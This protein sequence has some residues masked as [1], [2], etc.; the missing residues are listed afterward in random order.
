[1][2]DPKNKINTK[3][4]FT[5]IIDIGKKLGSPLDPLELASVLEKEKIKRGQGTN[6]VLNDES[7]SKYNDEEQM[8]I[9]EL[10]KNTQITHN[11]YKQVEAFPMYKPKFGKNNVMQLL[12]PNINYSKGAEYNKPDLEF[13]WNGSMIP[14][15]NMTKDELADT[16]PFLLDTKNNKI[17]SMDKN[18]L[19]E[20]TDDWSFSN[21]GQNIVKTFSDPIKAFGAAVGFDRDV[22][23]DFLQNLGFS[24][25]A[26]LALTNYGDIAK[27]DT[28]EGKLAKQMIE[29]GTVNAK[30]D[31]KKKD[32]DGNDR[33]MWKTLTDDHDS[34]Q[35]QIRSVWGP[36]TMYNNNLGMEL[37]ETSNDFLLDSLGAANFIF[38]YAPKKLVGVASKYLMDGQYDKQVEKEYNNYNAWAEGRKSAGSEEEDLGWNHNI[39]NFSKGV[40]NGVAQVASS[41]AMGGVGKAAVWGLSKAGTQMVA[42]GIMTG[43]TKGAIS[44]TGNALFKL[45]PRI[46]KAL[47]T[48]PATGFGYT[49]AASSANKEA[50]QSGINAEASLVMAGIAALAVVGSEKLTGGNWV[51]KLLGKEVAEKYGVEVAKR[52]SNEIKRANRLQFNNEITETVLN[53]TASKG[54]IKK[55]L[56]EAYEFISKDATNP[57]EG[58]IQGV[59]KEGGQEVI[60]DTINKSAQAGFNAIGDASKS[61]GLDW[62]GD[63]ERYH[64]E[65]DNL[66]ED[67]AGSFVMGGIV[68]GMTGAVSY[69][70]EAE[71]N[72]ERSRT[73]EIVAARLK[74]DKVSEKL[75]STLD[76]MKDKGLFGSSSLSSENEKVDKKWSAKIFDKFKARKDNNGNNVELDDNE[77][78][79]KIHRQEVEETF[80]QVDMVVAELEKVYGK[81]LDKTTEE[82]AELVSSI[83]GMSENT[84]PNTDI[85]RGLD[86]IPE[87]NTQTATIRDSEGNL[88]AMSQEDYDEL[89]KDK[90]LE[91]INNN[92]QTLT[93]V[94]RAKEEVKLLRQTL[95]QS[96]SSEAVYVKKQ[97]DTAEANIAHLLY[98][99]NTSNT[100]GLGGID[101]NNLIV[102]NGNLKGIKK[103]INTDDNNDTQDVYADIMVKNQYMKANEALTKLKEDT[104]I[105][106]MFDNM[107]K[108]NKDLR[109]LDFN[110]ERA[111]PEEKAAIEVAIKSKENELETIEN[112]IDTA[113]KDKKYVTPA[114]AKDLRTLMQ[115]RRVY[116]KH[117]ES[118]ITKRFEFF[119]EKAAINVAATY[120]LAAL[121]TRAKESGMNRSILSPY[122]KAE[123]EKR[124]KYFIDKIKNQ[125]VAS[126]KFN[127]DQKAAS[128]R[129]KKMIEDN[130]NQFN[131]TIIEEMLKYYDKPSIPIAQDLKDLFDLAESKSTAD[132]ITNLKKNFS[133]FFNNLVNFNETNAL[134]T[135]SGQI[136]KNANPAFDTDVI[137]AESK[138]N[139]DLII[140]S[141]NDLANKGNADPKINKKLKHLTKELSLINSTSINR[142]GE[143]IVNDIIALLSNDYALENSSDLLPADSE[144]NL[145]YF[146]GTE[147][148]YS[149]EDEI[150]GD[151]DPF[152]FIESALTNYIDNIDT[153]KAIEYLKDPN[154]DIN[155]IKSFNNKINSL[156]KLKSNPN[157]LDD[158]NISKDEDLSKEFYLNDNS[159]LKDNRGVTIPAQIEEDIVKEIKGDIAEIDVTKLVNNVNKSYEPLVSILLNQYTGEIESKPIEKEVYNPDSQIDTLLRDYFTKG[160]NDQQKAELRALV[161]EYVQSFDGGDFDTVGLS[162]FSRLA[163]SHIVGTKLAEKVGFKLKSRLVQDT[164]YR[165]KYLDHYLD[166][167]KSISVAAAFNDDELDKE[168][169]KLENEIIALETEKKFRLTEDLPTDLDKSLEIDE[170]INKLLL[171]LQKIELK[172]SEKI[173]ASTFNIKPLISTI[174]KSYKPEIIRTLYKAENTELDTPLMPSD[175]NTT[176]NLEATINYL[177]ILRSNKLQNFYNALFDSA[178]L[179]DENTEFTSTFEQQQVSKDLHAMFSGGNY[180]SSKSEDFWNEVAS[181]IEESVRLNTSSTAGFYNKGNLDSKTT[182]ESIKAYFNVKLIRGYAGTGKTTFII[183]EIIKIISQHKDYKSKDK[184]RILVSAPAKNQLETIEKEINTLLGLM[185]NEYKIDNV[186]IVTIK[187][188]DILTMDKK[189][190]TKDYDTIIID[191][192][193]LASYEELNKNTNGAKELFTGFKKPILLAGDEIQKSQ[194]GW[195]TNP[196]TRAYTNSSF[197]IP[198]TV[199]LVNPMRTG[200]ID[201][202]NLQKNII[203]A[204]V[205]LSKINSMYI[206]NGDVDFKASNKN[207]SKELGNKSIKVSGSNFQEI[208]KKILSFTLFNP[209]SSRYTSNSEGVIENGVKIHE[210]GLSSLVVAEFKTRVKNNPKDDTKLIIVGDETLKNRII[211]EEGLEDISSNVITAMESQGQ[212]IDNVYVYTTPILD[213]TASELLET[214]KDLFVAVS[215]EKKT[216][217][218]SMS[219]VEG[220]DIN[221][222]KGL[223]SMRVN[224]KT[225]INQFVS[226]M[227]ENDKGEMVINDD[228]KN[229]QGST[230][231][232][233]K[234]YSDG[235]KETESEEEE[236]DSGNPVGGGS[237]PGS[238]GTGSGTGGKSA[239]DLRKEKE[240][241]DKAD[242]AYKT[243]HG[244]AS[245][246]D[247][248][249]I[250]DTPL[251]KDDFYT[252]DYDKLFKGETNE[253][254]QIKIIQQELKNIEL[255]NSTFHVDPNDDTKAT[256]TINK[257]R[258]AD[259]KIDSYLK[260]KQKLIQDKIDL[261]KK[262]T[263]KSKEELE[264]EEADKQAREEAE[265]KAEEERKKKAKDNGKSNYVDTADWLV[266]EDN[267]FSFQNLYKINYDKL[268]KGVINKEKQIDI[269][270]KEILN[271]AYFNSTLVPN[272]D[273]IAT[274]TT[275]PYNPDDFEIDR[276]L[277]DKIIS[278]QKEINKEK[279]EA[280]RKANE[281]P[282]FETFDTDYTILQTY[283]K[284]V[285]KIT[286]LLN[287]NISDEDVDIETLSDNLSNADTFIRSSSTSLNPARFT[288][289]KNVSG[290]KITADQIKFM[291]DFDSMP[292]DVL[293]G[294]NDAILKRIALSPLQGK[295]YVKYI[296]PQYQ[297]KVDTLKLAYNKAKE[298][299]D[300]SS[301]TEKDIKEIEAN[302]I[303]PPTLELGKAKSVNG[304][305]KKLNDYRNLLIE[306]YKDYIETESFKAVMEEFESMFKTLKNDTDKLTSM[307]II[308]NIIIGKYT[309]SELTNKLKNNL[310]LALSKDKI[311]NLKSS[312]DNIT[313]IIKKEISNKIEKEKLKSTQ[314]GLPTSVVEIEGYEGLVSSLIA[315]N[316]FGDTLQDNKDT[317]DNIKLFGELVLGAKNVVY[318]TK[319]M[320]EPVKLEFEEN[321]KKELTLKIII[322]NG[323]INDKKAIHTYIAS[324]LSNNLFL[325]IVKGDKLRRYVYD[326]TSHSKSIFDA[327]S[328]EISAIYDILATALEG[329][330]NGNSLLSQAITAVSLTLD[331][332]GEVADFKAKIDEVFTP[333][334][335]KLISE[336]KSKAS[337]IAVG[338]LAVNT[339]IYDILA[340]VTLDPRIADIFKNIKPSGKSTYVLLVEK[341]F[342]RIRNNSDTIT[343]NIM[344]KIQ[345]PVLKVA[346][347][348]VGNKSLKVTSLEEQK[349]KDIIRGEVN[350]ESMS[351]LVF[352]ED[353][354]LSFIEE[355]SGK[356]IGKNELE[357]IELFSNCLKNNKK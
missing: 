241:K 121:L 328:N 295:A 284:E 174:F 127:D 49:Y 221:L 311:T 43:L 204:I 273:I 182:K 322:S 316:V 224:D 66:F 5:D 56:G 58:A 305:I 97:L 156:K 12:Y 350:I 60:E 9:K 55:V 72:M 157:P 40:L 102:S 264:K 117:L 103:N 250:E 90:S 237:N 48:A 85:L 200:K 232:L 178:I 83:L 150:M 276:I 205:E 165:A 280:R 134:D 198:R 303:V 81:D 129:F 344:Q 252:I 332:E 113:F 202:F 187:L 146:D 229:R 315:A 259:A 33:Y 164:E 228:L 302:E 320:L 336:N 337:K 343:D 114:K 172:V 32:D 222:I 141:L 356:L 290:E 22:N 294:I 282:P 231:E 331:S 213:T 357:A 206:K 275:N 314:L 274:F 215:R 191:E 218:V 50:R 7:L 340:A 68:G 17:I 151:V 105:A 253:E 325:S 210:P 35:E 3:I 248:V 223:D 304:I 212:S 333:K 38:N 249:K 342:E 267:P 16:A 324:L 57:F 169:E 236:D 142:K 111:L 175:K 54:A 355:I 244:Y 137:L 297:A 21:I 347:Q 335:L 110:L 4:D 327:K 92:F 126:K 101:P 10:Y 30:T 145:V 300:K 163:L 112:E 84:S 108:I 88:Q 115:S 268:F 53:N 242:A 139:F 345:E 52:L 260:V 118:G 44:E 135:L 188:E 34:F 120:K 71:K 87:Y 75:L 149:I 234:S 339:A 301:L 42:K 186:E 349:G 37:L 167:L 308:N 306:S 334:R 239:E 289:R 211:K 15:R 173:T 321:K 313:N 138:V 197:I 168:I 285:D 80:A 279:D 318:E 192:A 199:P 196:W 70:K 217:T 283:I 230:F 155:T 270:K 31:Y 19:E 291:T 351:D 13:S 352:K 176:E 122:T 161:L 136:V 251:I 119:K 160:L 219:K 317:I 116:E 287:D 6:F 131:D 76:D 159:K 14:I 41:L 91:E 346:K 338:D 125:E 109:Q 124:K 77:F 214:I 47:V 1:M 190:L 254:N 82:Y 180:T 25:D 128:S 293:A 281:E 238:G 143:D 79:Y 185:K 201:S 78:R 98:T 353:E 312:I 299:F 329:T 144:G 277:K 255:E 226:P 266:I 310:N 263:P 148:P 123:K 286:S 65:T 203:S 20:M 233:L 104:E 184:I 256:T 63:K 247:W 140:T 18:K 245:K 183:K 208:A 207:L 189:Q 86:I 292:P 309:L 261:E 23:E 93:P 194:G 209:L 46:T 243:K 132:N 220:I 269:L 179:S 262:G 240:A 323:V 59:V 106:A 24:G 147:E 272:K 69:K 26:R 181:N 11:A 51:N 330:E 154:S 162:A 195:G 28:E 193:T 95:K 271:I 96:V 288:D 29:M 67:L 258:S 62:I 348:S 36:K 257:Y 166:M 153:L 27:L 61:L 2:P 171:S 170:A 235:N 265:R 64:I 177:N 319:S 45:S 225:L 74:G 130:G 133:A 99:S 227:V 341:T 89:T 158:V 73:N 216:L 296:L 298:I 307:D 152:D 107:S 94:E 246:V 8:A 39:T 100:E 326:D 278:I 354:L